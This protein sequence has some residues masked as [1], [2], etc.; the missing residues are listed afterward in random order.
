MSETDV[1]EGDLGPIRRP[2]RPISS[3][4][5]KG[6]LHLVRPI[7]TTWPQ[8]HVRIRDVG[9]PLAIARKFK[10][11]GGNPIEVGLEAVG[12]RVVAGRFNAQLL[13]GH[14][15]FFPIR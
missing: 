4:W 1:D 6:E 15:E 12:L 14:K 13:A 10:T 11:T 3:G 8:A 2:P 7:R 5:R 9:N